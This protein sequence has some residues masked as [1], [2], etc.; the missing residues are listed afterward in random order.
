MPDPSCGPDCGRLAGMVEVKRMMFRN[1]VTLLL[2]AVWNVVRCRAV[3]S[4]LWELLTMAG[5]NGG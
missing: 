3:A 4:C 1:F 2:I 5:L